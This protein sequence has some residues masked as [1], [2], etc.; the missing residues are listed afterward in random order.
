SAPSRGLMC[1]RTEKGVP[2]AVRYLIAPNDGGDSIGREL[3]GNAVTGMSLEVSALEQRSEFA[4]GVP[5]QQH[6]HA[7]ARAAR[8]DPVT[9]G[10]LGGI[11]REHGEGCAQPTIE[12]GDGRLV[13]IQ[14]GEASMRG[15]RVNLSRQ[16]GKIVPAI[17]RR[18]HRE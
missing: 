2:T 4:R 7:C 12:N 11:G 14:Q 13:R 3:C 1:S 9:Y 8:A 16:C 10:A 5:R 17:Y 18:K 6:E 15:I